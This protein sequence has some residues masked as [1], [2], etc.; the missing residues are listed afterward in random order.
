MAQ[1]QNVGKR[2]RLRTL[3]CCTRAAVL[4][5]DLEIRR[6]IHAVSRTNGRFFRCAAALSF[7]LMPHFSC[8]ERAQHKSTMTAL[9]SWTKP[10]ARHLRLLRS[11]Y[12]LI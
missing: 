3:L 6:S 10:L 5:C 2:R 12:F 9:G 4:S 11:F 1:V 8:C 7:S